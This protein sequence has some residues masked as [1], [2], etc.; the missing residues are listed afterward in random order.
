MELGVQRNKVK[1]IFLNNDLFSISDTYNINISGVQYKYNTVYKT[2]VNQT[3][4]TNTQPENG[5]CY[6][7]K[8]T[9]TLADGITKTAKWCYCKNKD[10]CNSSVRDFLNYGLVTLLIIIHFF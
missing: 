10:Y 9:T 6:D 1:I 7:M 5:K 4:D 2:C 3:V 8:N